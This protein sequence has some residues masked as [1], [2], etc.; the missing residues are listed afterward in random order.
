[1]TATPPHLESDSPDSAPNRESTEGHESHFASRVRTAVIWR[2]GAQVGSQIITWTSTFLVVRLLDPT[3]YGLFAMSQVVVTA[4]AFLNGASFATSLVQANHVDERRIGQ[5]FGMLLLA[6]F[7][8]AAV[9]FLLAPGAAE[10]FG[11]PIVADM[12]RLQAIIFLT[13]PFTALPAE[14]LARSLDFRKAGQVNMGSAVI[15]AL[16]ALVLAWLGW[17]VWALI[18][19]GLAIF[20]SRAVGLMIAAK[21]WVRPIFDP[22]GAMDLFTFGG[23]LTLCQLFW[24]IQSQSDVVIAGRLL[25]THD[26]GLYTQALFLTLIVTGRFIPPINEVALA[27][28]SE[29]HRAKKPLAPYFLKTVRLVMMVCAPVYIGLA[30]TAEDAIPVL[31]GEKWTGIVPVVAG[32]ALTMPAFA[33]HLICSPVTNAMGRPRVYLFTS[34]AGAV[35]FPVMFA[36]GVSGG[37]MGLAQ[38]WWVAAPLL[39]AVTLSVTL[40]RIGVS[41]LDLADALAPIVLACAAMAIVVLF[42]QSLIVIENPLLA[43]VKNAALGA[44][45]YAATFWFFYRGI[46]R[47]TWALLRK[48]DSAPAAA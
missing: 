12:L 36:W 34:V 17:G 21:L 41:L 29:L 18:Y 39:C 11:E 26:L 45:V 3:D 9:Q 47:E 8:L 33:L 31:M 43:L 42:A 25:D 5:V 30:L 32:L 22:R 28:Y 2:W 16:T 1:M 7:T 46:V 44:S 38:A 35:I 13:V 20:V 37:P 24:I 40:P 27:A 48:G 14:W 10:Y 6:N 4:L 23:T 15:G 19:A